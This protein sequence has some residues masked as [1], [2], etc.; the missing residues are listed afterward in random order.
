MIDLPFDGSAFQTGAGCIAVCQQR[1]PEFILQQAIS[2]GIDQIVQRDS[3]AF[4]KEIK[5]SQIMIKEPRKFFEAPLCTIL[6]PMEISKEREKQHT[7][8]SATC[9]SREQRNTVIAQFAG[10]MSGQINDG[11]LSDVKLIVSELASNAVLHAAS[12][13]AGLLGQ[14]DN[15]TT[16][17]TD[18]ALLRPSHL[19]L[20]HDEERL[21]ICCRDDYGALDVTGLL[22]RIRK[23]FAYGL[24][25][26][27]NFGK[28]GA[29]VGTYMLFRAALS[30]YVAVNEGRQT[31][32]CV[33]LP[34]R[35]G[36][37]QRES[38]SKNLH[39]FKGKPESM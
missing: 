6:N 13:E 25:P 22:E 21:V 16:P 27:M 10:K 35:G 3:L 31:M 29:G 14:S 9:S 38:M 4:E 34:M 12:P 23:C 32:I 24:A 26:M 28:G 39:I 19:K 30:L 20:G 18:R 1:E 36:Q 11:L 2:F 8:I 7:S 5:T 33:T 15:K 17:P 37:R